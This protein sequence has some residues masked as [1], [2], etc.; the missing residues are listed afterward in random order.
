MRRVLAIA[1]LT[2]KAAFRYRLVIVLGILLLATVVLLP[3]FIKHDGTARGF[4]QILM[5]YTLGSITAFLGLATLWMSCGT[6]AR[7]VEEC[8][9]QMLVVKPVARWQIWLG[10]W[11]GIMWVNLFLLGVSG[12]AVYGLMQWRAGQLTPEQQA[13][14]H[15]EVLVARGSAREPIPDW[16]SVV[17][18]VMAKQTA[19]RDLSSLDLNLLRKQIE[20]QAKAQYQLVLPNWSRRWEIP[21]G[22]ASRTVKDKPLYLRV[23]FMAASQ[24]YV[25]EMSPVRT[26]IATWQVGKPETPRVW[27]DQMSL[28]AAAYHEFAV[29]PNLL[30]EKGVL[31]I[32]FINRNEETLL[33]PLEDGMEVLYRE[34][35]F[36]VNYL[37]A[38]GIILCWLSLFAVVGLTAA[39]FL[40]FPVAS[41]LAMS[42]LI[43][44]L[45]SGTLS[46][47]I[48]EGGVTGVNHDTGRIDH[49]LWLDQ[50]VVALFKVILRLI[51][52]VSGFSPIDLLC[53]GRSV[54]WPMLALAVGQIVC[55]LGGIIAAIGI[56]LF[57]RRELATAQGNQ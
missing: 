18:Q 4:T 39:S 24:V 32:E 46:Q 56:G 11:L 47:V 41:F 19:K 30:D 15:N 36:T 57:T 40:S 34:G 45:S 54:S 48:E 7:D 42:L 29:P 3:I 31:T 51:N 33:F 55:L 16:S 21:L 38:M 49:P 10:K 52:L 25:D 20:E 22:L 2:W 44:G 35:G 8:Q 28:A 5:T 13:V 6:L 17:D 43:V 37:R 14:L 27:R 1:L 9:I 26:F 50:G 23:K 53:S 12:G